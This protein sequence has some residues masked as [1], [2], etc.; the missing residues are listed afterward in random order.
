MAAKS[1]DL[2][3]I[4]AG[5]GG[6]VAAI[7]GAQL[8]LSVA[9]VEREHLGG[10]C[11]NWGCIPT[12]ALLRSSEVFHLMQ[13][14][15]EFG[16]KADNIGYDLEA[17]VKRSRKVA[18][19]L[20]GGIGHLMKKNKVSV[21]MGAATLAGKGKVSVKS[22]DGEETL[23]AKNIVL[24]TGARA[25]NLPGLEADGKRVWMY[26]DALQPPHMPKK[27]LV[28]GS[29]A[30]GIEFASFYNTLGADTTVVEVMDRIL[31]VEDEEISKFAKKQFE[32]QGMKIMQ[33]AVVKQLDRADDKVTAHIETGGKVT[34]HEFD[35]V[36]SAVG[37]VGNVEDLGLEDLGV[38]VDRTHVVTDEY[39]RTGV[40]GLYAIGDIA[41]APWLAHKASHEGVMVAELI[42]GQHAHPVKPESIAG[43][44]YCHP[45]VA[46][47]GYT[48][49]KAK[50][51]GF[52]VKVGRFPFIG[53][54]KAIALGEPEGMIKTVF[55]AKTGELLGAHMV[56]A[57]VTE[58]IQGY[59]VGRQLETTEE[60]LM[61]TVFPHPTLSEM[62]HESVLDAYGRV[63]HM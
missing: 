15:S 36:I 3:V 24:A 26:K 52:D 62:M 23:T 14:A 19:Q 4:G 30:I 59:V 29:G 35:T 51:L 43:C 11:L 39:C 8:G 1:F 42:A 25:R 49:A 18:G 22:K 57:E 60:D 41:G 38:K 63:I 58:L 47:V 6:Y 2:I 7:R 50:E 44:T 32:K 13:R 28:I 12:K 61:N 31:P 16:L 20:S 40:E 21:F 34:K 53:N 45:Q 46:S 5:P 54:G 55:D 33:K 10:I 48:E 9:I 17:V 27:L 37:I 56:G